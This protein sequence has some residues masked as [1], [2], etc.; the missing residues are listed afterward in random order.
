MLA[1]ASGQV[2]ICNPGIPFTQGYFVPSLIEI[3]P[4]GSG[5]EDENV[6]SLQTDGQTNE[7]NEIYL[8]KNL[9]CLKT[10]SNILRLIIFFYEQWYDK[11]EQTTHY[12]V[13]ET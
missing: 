3:W 11:A 8:T 1:F 4:S 6:K 10:G 7:G 9:I 2:V 13:F 5:E 12:D